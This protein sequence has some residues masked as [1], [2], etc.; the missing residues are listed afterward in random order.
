MYRRAGE[1]PPLDVIVVDEA[2]RIPPR[3]EGKYRRF[4]KEARAINPRAIVV[5]FTAT[6]FRLSSGPICHRDHVRYTAF[7]S[8]EN[9]P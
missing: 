5:G 4:I 1:F 6:P 2:H 3:G 9:T 8:V 7:V